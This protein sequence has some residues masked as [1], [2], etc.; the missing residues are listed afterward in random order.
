MEHVGLDWEMTKLKIRSF[1]VPYSINKKKEK[2]AFRKNLEIELKKLDEIHDINII[3]NFTTT[4][5]ELEQIEQKESNS[6]I[7]ISKIGWTDEGE[8]TQSIV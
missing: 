3:Q 6:L 1:S 7:F 8:K 5:R 2:S 4:K